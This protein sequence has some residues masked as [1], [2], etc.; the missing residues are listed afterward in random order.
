MELCIS[1]AF[2][3]FPLRRLWEVRNRGTAGIR[4]GCGHS[5]ADGSMDA[6]QAAA[7]LLV[8]LLVTDWSHADGP[9]G[10][11][12]GDQIFMVSE[13]ARPHLT[14]FLDLGLRLLEK[15]MATHSSILAWRIPWTEEPGRLQSMGS[16]RVRH[17]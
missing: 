11:D 12:G 16:Q 9:G 15:E 4:G 7:L 14:I 10:R 3:R 13:H 2:S 1:I 5:K 6:R 17:N 8:L